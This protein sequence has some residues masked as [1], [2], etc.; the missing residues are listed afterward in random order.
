M[1]SIPNAKHQ[2]QLSPTKRLRATATQVNSH[3][4]IVVFVGH[5]YSFSSVWGAALRLSP[6]CFLAA[7]SVRYLKSASRSQTVLLPVVYG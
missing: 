2:W 1:R 5:D 4:H 6:H 7:E 3:F